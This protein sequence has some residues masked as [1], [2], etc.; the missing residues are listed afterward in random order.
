MGV[1]AIVG[2]AHGLF[3]IHALAS[4]ACATSREQA[5]SA[6]S[7]PFAFR[8][9]TN[10]P[11]LPRRHGM[12][13][14]AAY[15]RTGRPS[16]DSRSGMTPPLVLTGEPTGPRG[17]ISLM[18]VVVSSSPE[19]L[20]RPGNTRANGKNPIGRPNPVKGL[21]VTSPAPARGASPLRLR[22]TGCRPARGLG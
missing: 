6:H 16:L 9:D 17:P 15:R 3:P 12:V 21:R 19:A 5:D 2:A 1:Q 4:R 22:P 20:C 8:A 11:L 10:P 14:R 18:P 13:M 7:A